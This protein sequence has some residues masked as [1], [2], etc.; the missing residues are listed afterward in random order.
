MSPDFSG[1]EK[2][3]VVQ[4]SRLHRRRCASVDHTQG[5]ERRLK[6]DKFGA[7]HE[8]SGSK[9]VVVGGRSGSEGRL[10]SSGKVGARVDGGWVIPCAASWWISGGS[11]S[12]RKLRAGL[13]RLW[14]WSWIAGWSG[15]RGP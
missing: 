7:G 1:V 4:L 5:G 11:V 3:G 6:W 13:P 12:S 10:G 9:L 8:V 2:G 14:G 15:G